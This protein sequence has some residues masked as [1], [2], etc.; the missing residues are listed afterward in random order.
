MTTWVERLKERMDTAGIS[1]EALA[2]KLGIT[3]GAITHYLTGRRIPPINQFQKM[4]S[5]LN[6]E[7][8]WL[9]Y[10]IETTKPEDNKIINKNEFNKIPVPILNWEQIT[11]KNLSKIHDDYIPG[12]YSLTPIYGLRVKGDSM[13]SP[14]GQ[15][16]SFLENEILIVDPNAIATHGTFVI[17]LLKVTKE[18]TFKQF[19]IDNGVK[20]LK[21]LNPQYPLY[22]IANENAHICGVVLGRMTIFSQSF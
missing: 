10:G 7:P 1:R 6:T 2:Q 15:Q 14:T 8:A 16:I 21:P 4:A 22:E 18:V 9:Q 3:Y 13:T 20:Y 5:I 19:V 12:L 17:A 11:Q